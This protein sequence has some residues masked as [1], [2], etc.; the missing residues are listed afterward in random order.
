M[1][2]ATGAD[3][4]RAYHSAT[5]H[6][7]DHDRSRLVRFRPLDPTN[8]PSPF[9]EYV[10]LDAAPLAD[11][12]PVG[13][14]LFFGGGVT[15]VSAT[16][17]FRTAMSAG[18]LHPVEL[19]V[20]DAGLGVRHYDPLHHALTTIRGGGGAGPPVAVVLTG[21]PWRT[22]WKYGERGWRHLYWDSGA[23]AANMLAVDTEARTV[24]DFDDAALSR[25]LGLDGTSEFPLAVVQLGDAALDVP[26]D[27]PTLDLETAPLSRAPIEFP[28]ITEIQRAT[29]PFSGRL[30]AYRG[31]KRPNLGEEPIEELILRRGSTRLFR[32]E[33]VPERAF[34]EPMAVAADG[35]PLLE[36]I[37]AVHAVEGLDANPREVTQHL[38][39]DQPLGGDSA[40]T[41]FH[42]AH[43]DRVLDDIGPRGYRAALFEAGLAAERLELAAFSV[44]L[45]ATGLTFY[46][47][48][49]KATFGTDAA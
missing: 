32:R 40:Y 20:V 26:D 35:A 11:D 1:S 38:C 33:E 12:D 16:S 15:R 25:L 19:Y 30:H 13:R 44:G 2:Q 5:T 34:R 31:V 29:T 39:Y 14:L 6:G 4:V 42:S 24:L 21:I 28:L 36:H 22:S 48:E 47:D 27:V 17:Y 3:A 43:L 49:V 23:V 9:K 7:G 46:D 41:V 37:V 18:N 45:G 8:R 10:G